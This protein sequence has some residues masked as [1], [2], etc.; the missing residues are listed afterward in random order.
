MSESSSVGTVSSSCY[1]DTACSNFLEQSLISG[2]CNSPVAQNPTSSLAGKRRLLCSP[3]PCT[4]LLVSLCP[5]FKA[6]SLAS[7]EACCARQAELPLT[8]GSRKPHSTPSMAG[9]QLQHGRTLNVCG[10]GEISARKL[11]YSTVILSLRPRL[12]V[13]EHR[14]SQTATSQSLL[15]NILCSLLEN[16][17][18]TC[19]SMH[20]FS[21][22]YPT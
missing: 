10:M 18:S 8:P 7:S 13:T 3:L 12:R 17:E 4:Q 19:P 9:T 6:G 20:H 21:T 1:A 22:V 11:I 2:G 16:R 14:V 15:L 5:P